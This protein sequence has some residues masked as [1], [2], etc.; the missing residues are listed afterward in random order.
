M[1]SFMEFIR[2]VTEEKLSHLSFL[3]ENVNYLQFVSLFPGVPCALET[4]GYRVAPAKAT[5]KRSAIFV[6]LS[7]CKFI[8]I[9][10]EQDYS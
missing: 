3:T 8:S 7:L 4:A 5:G 9:S 2:C 10:N 6:S 1:T